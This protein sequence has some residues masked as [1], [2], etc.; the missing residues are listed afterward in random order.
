MKQIKLLKM[1]NKIIKTENGLGVE[2]F[3]VWNT[4]H[5]LEKDKKIEMLEN[6]MD[7]STE[8]L[9]KIKLRIEY[10][11]NADMNIGIY[12]KEK[13]EELVDK[14]IPQVQWKLGQEEIIQRA[15]R[16]ALIAVDELIEE[17]IGYLSV[18]RNKYW[19]KVKQEIKK[20]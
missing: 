13:A 7:W 17:S 2:V 20:L 5:S 12:K 8:E 3:R 15:K 19:K 6:I 1:E 10:T 16:C 18:D 4:Y 9:E 11:S 14:F